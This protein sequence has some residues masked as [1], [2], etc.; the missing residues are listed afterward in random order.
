MSHSIIHCLAVFIGGGCGTLF[1]FYVVFKFTHSVPI[2]SSSAATMSINIV[3][4]FLIGI[5]H[6]LLTHY[7]CPDWLKLLL[8]SGVLGGFTTFS[9]FGLDAV[10]MMQSHQ[11]SAVLM[12]LA[13]SVFGG[14]GVVW[15]GIYL[16]NRWLLF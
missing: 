15:C 7:M 4:C 14:L 12:Y 9:T 6:T 10:M 5:V 13:V 8:I 16:T 11:A 2:L 1:R 3:G